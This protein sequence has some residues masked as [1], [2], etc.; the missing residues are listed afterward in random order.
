MAEENQV[1]Q[2]VENENEE[3]KK[4]QTNESVTETNEETKENEQE[5][6]QENEQETSDIS[7]EENTDEEQE[8]TEE[9]QETQTAG[10][11]IRVEDLV[12]KDML[13]DR[14]SALEAKFDAVV[15]ENEDLKNAL[16]QKSDELNGMKDKY[17]NKDFGNMQKQGMME[18][19]KY[20]NSSFDEYSK[21]FM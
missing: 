15:K 6:K 8:P 3:I 11:G 13:A 18:K 14:L 17:E 10:N 4:D 21:Q 20:A 9:V 1:N 16:S 19:D 12:T 7:K 5:N 2:K